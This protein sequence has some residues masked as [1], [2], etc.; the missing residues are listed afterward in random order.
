[1]KSRGRG[2]TILELIIV[3]AIIG[4]LLTILFTLLDESREKGRDAK[5][6][7]ETRE[8]SSALELYFVTNE[9]YPTAAGESKDEEDYIDITGEDYVSTDLVEGGHIPRMPTD[10]LQRDPYLYRYDTDEEG[11]SF[12]LTFCLERDDDPCP[13]REIAR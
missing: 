7:R 1:M 13:N 11:E 10:P 9:R 2:F 5:R 8:I 12:S 6:L 3:V 4:I